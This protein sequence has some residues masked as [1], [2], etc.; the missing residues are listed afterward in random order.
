VAYSADGTLP[1]GAD[2]A[3]FDAVLHKLRKVMAAQ[4]VERTS[5]LKFDKDTRLRAHDDGVRLFQN[6]C[7]YIRQRQQDFPEALIA[8]SPLYVEPVAPPSTEAPKPE[9]PAP[10]TDARHRQPACW[11]EPLL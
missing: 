11:T 1:E 4:L 9:C 2:K 6:A 7:D 3:L 10:P 5:V 8:G